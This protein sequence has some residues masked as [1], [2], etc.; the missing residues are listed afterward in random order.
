MSTK[1]TSNDA[2]KEEN[3]RKNRS[4]FIVKCHKG[5]SKN[6]RLCKLSTKTRYVLR[7]NRAK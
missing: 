5:V 1:S 2:Q 6:E 7:E 4:L 3:N